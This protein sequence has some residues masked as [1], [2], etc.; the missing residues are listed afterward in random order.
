MR[1]RGLGKVAPAPAKMIG[2]FNGTVGPDWIL[3]PA[4]SWMLE[5]T[6]GFDIHADCVKIENMIR[7]PS[8]FAELRLRTFIIRFGLRLGASDIAAI[9]RLYCYVT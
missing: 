4:L 1:I 5:M 2:T 3:D 8:N 9:E 6:A 7:I